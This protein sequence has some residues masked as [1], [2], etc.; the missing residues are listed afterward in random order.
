MVMIHAPKVRCRVGRVQRSVRHA[1][2]RE[3]IHHGMCL[4]RSSHRG[5]SAGLVIRLRTNQS[6]EAGVFTS[7]LNVST[8]RMR[9]LDVLEAAAIM[10]GLPMAGGPR[11]GIDLGK[12]Q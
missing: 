1:C 11:A 7:A 6:V 12:C 4:G 8:Y 9:R 10:G 3:D 5:D 2:G